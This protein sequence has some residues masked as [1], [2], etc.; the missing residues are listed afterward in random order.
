MI[1]K[2]GDEVPQKVTK[3]WINAGKWEVDIA[4]KRYPAKASAVPMYDPK[5]EKIKA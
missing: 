4:G 3:K 5:N 2:N 1:N